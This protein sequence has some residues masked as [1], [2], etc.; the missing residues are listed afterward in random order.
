[1]S[2]NAKIFLA[3]ILVLSIS[4]GLSPAYAAAPK[5]HLK[6]LEPPPGLPA[7]IEI[8]GPAAL[9]FGG[10]LEELEL[11]S[12]VLRPAT[13]AFYDRAL[14]DYGSLPGEF[15]FMQEQL[16]KYCDSSTA[17][18]VKTAAAAVRLEIERTAGDWSLDKILIVVAVGVVSLAVG[19]AAGAFL[20]LSG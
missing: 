17:A 2:V 3:T 9:D 4:T 6:I 10:E 7:A 8:D 20:A 11:G 19:I 5:L 13:A 14:R 15:E 16:V 18:A 1:M 12:W